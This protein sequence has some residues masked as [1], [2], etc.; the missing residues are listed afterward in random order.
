MTDFTVAVD[1][2]VKAAKAQQDAALR[3]YAEALAER[4]KE[5]TPVKTGFLRANWMVVVSAEAL[6]TSRANQLQGDEISRAKIG[7]DILV[8]NPA[9]YA[10]RIEYGFM[11]TDSRG[12]TYHQAPRGMVAQTLTEA[13]QILADVLKRLNRS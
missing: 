12:R 10:R 3:A 7:A 9:A 11:G 5:L 1:A 4:I 13:P 8:L 6:P 2:W